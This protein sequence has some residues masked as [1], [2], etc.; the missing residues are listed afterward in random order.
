MA[1]LEVKRASVDPLLLEAVHPGAR[2]IRREISLR[3]AADRALRET[4]VA[5][6]R[7]E[8]MSVLILHGR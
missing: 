5:F 3:T 7:L 6:D 4:L 1:V 8:S 2:T